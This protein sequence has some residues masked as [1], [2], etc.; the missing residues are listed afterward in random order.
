MCPSAR[1]RSRGIFY[2][3]V[4]TPDRVS[5]ISN[6]IFKQCRWTRTGETMYKIDKKV[7]AIVVERSAGRCENCGKAFHRKPSLH[8]IL[9]RKPG[10]VDDIHNIIYLC[11]DC[12]SG[13]NGVHGRD[14]HALDLKLKIRC[15][16]AY[17]NEGYSEAEVRIKMG[18]RL[19]FQEVA[20]VIKT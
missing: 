4:H 19:Y 14:G 20:G 9:K 15:Q 8:H 10:L 16:E 7:A 1:H 13:T 3:V 17:F 6:H 2:L 5:H 18:R 11:Y 12:D